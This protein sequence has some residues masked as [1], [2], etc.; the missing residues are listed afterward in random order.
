MKQEEYIKISEYI[1]NT[2]Y[3]EKIIYYINEIATKIVYVAFMTLIILNIGYK[4]EELV[5]VILV[6]G[7]SFVLVSVV[8][9]KINSK[10]P[11]TIYNFKPIIKKDKQGE[12]MPSRHV[13]SAFIIGMAYLYM[14]PELC[15][16]I[17]ISGIVIAIVRVIGGV[18]FLKDVFWGAILGIL[19]GVV[20]FYIV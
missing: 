8:R 18:H 11:Y 19:C 10:R 17:F 14:E 7:I 13:F 20:G 5:R 15:L 16:V 2:K 6:T 12:S 9:K 4:N 1:R 3:G